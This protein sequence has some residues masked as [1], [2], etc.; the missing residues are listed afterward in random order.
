M[1]LSL[2]VR[3]ERKMALIQMGTVEQGIE[4]L[5]VRVFHFWKLKFVDY[6]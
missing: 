5:V 6:F 2:V 3:N 4:A 1:S